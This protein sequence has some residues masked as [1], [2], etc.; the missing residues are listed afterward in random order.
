MSSRRIAA[1]ALVPI[2]ALSLAVSAEARG[3]STVAESG[4]TGRMPL[5]PADLQTQY[6]TVQA[7]ATG[8][9]YQK[10]TQGYATDRW[11]VSVK[12][13]NGAL[14]SRSQTQ[15][16]SLVASLTAKGFSPSTVD[17]T[18]PDAADLAGGPVG[19]AVRVGS[20]GTRQEA[21]TTQ[22]SL[23]A[24]GFG[25]TVTY[26]A[27]DGAA[28]T[29]PW[30]VRVLTI[31]P[32]AVN[33]RAV[34]GQELRSA[35]T[36]RSMASLAGAI[37]AVNGSDFD[38]STNPV[39][40][41]FDGDPTGIYVQNNALL[42]EPNNGRTALLMNGAGSPLRITELTS[43]TTVW[44]PN[45]DVW[46]VDGIH[47]MPGRIFG[48]GGIGGDIRQLT[49][50]SGELPHRGELCT[51][52]DE[53]VIFRPEWGSS[54]PVQPAG[55]DTV[56]VVM[57]GN[58]VVQQINSGSGGST[59]PAGARVVQGIGGGAAWLRQHATVGLAFT[60]GTS[61]V[62]TS[63]AKVTATGFN[64]VAGGPALVR[65]GQIY[66]NPAANGMTT[67]TGLPN[68]ALVQRHPRTVAGI[69]AS[70]QLLLVVIDGRQP[71]YSVGVTLPEAADVMRWLGAVEAVNLGGGGDS[72]L[73][74]NGVL[75]N[76]PTD[77]FGAGV[78]ERPVGNAIALLPK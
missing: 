48:C 5:G 35:E 33:L 8:V 75:Y 39:F 71:T 9:S 47:R 46:Q 51:D 31:D 59:I 34:H 36:V 3:A 52:P 72:T 13:S 32:A 1:A 49:G 20:Y 26:T 22:S 16:D 40:S 45:G 78:S 65:G 69:T 7:I 25:G 58:W 50:T 53:V 44:A 2:L 37:A 29:G 10:F 11:T 42:S 12:F 43:T 27:E 17:F 62:D 24:A 57:N 23:S 6:G 54:T 21:L 14:T 63:G 60:P 64:A 68:I 56:D 77:Y 30:E 66:L 55:V 61:I 18:A 67:S 41:G 73:I 28:S 19:T 15:V 76:R 74:A 38:I 4:P 70:G